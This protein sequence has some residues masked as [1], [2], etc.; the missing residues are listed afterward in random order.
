MHD[1]YDVLTLDMRR[2]FRLA[3]E[4]EAFPLHGVTGQQIG[5]FE[6]IAAGTKVRRL[7]HIADP[8]YPRVRFIVESGKE[9]QWVYLFYGVRLP[10]VLP[11]DSYPLDE[12]SK[13]SSS[14]EEDEIYSVKKGTKP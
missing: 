13:K 6:V 14:E 12:F 1:S 7:T 10:L 9:G 11:G 4:I 5:D 8:D 3:T 2:V